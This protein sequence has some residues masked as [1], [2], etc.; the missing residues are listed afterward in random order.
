MDEVN[1]AGGSSSALRNVVVFF[2][3]LAVALTLLT[4]AA[5]GALRSRGEPHWDC[6]LG[7]KLSSSG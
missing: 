4:G 7:P 5:S 2:V 1:V 3:V 6:Q